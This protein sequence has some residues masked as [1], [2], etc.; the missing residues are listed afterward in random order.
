[1]ELSR[2]E[3][4]EETDDSLR[5]V[6]EFSSDVIEEPT[7]I[8]YRFLYR[9]ANINIRENDDPHGH[10]V[11]LLG[12][13]AVTGY[14]GNFVQNYI[15]GF[16]AEQAGVC[17]Y[18][19]PTIVDV[20]DDVSGG[21]SAGR[22]SAEKSRIL[23]IEFRKTP[24]Y[25]LSDYNPLQVAVL[26]GSD[27]EA[28]AASLLKTL[29]R[30]FQQDVRPDDLKIV[31][32]EMTKR[33]FRRLQMKNM[34][35]EQ[36]CKKNNLD[37]ERLHTLIFKEALE[38]FKEDM[39]LDAIFRHHGLVCEKNDEQVILVQIEPDHPDSLK[40]QLEETYSAG[41]LRQAAERQRTRRWLM[42]TARFITDES[43][44]S[45]GGLSSAE[46]LRVIRETVSKMQA[47]APTTN[48]P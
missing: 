16:V 12:D 2:C 46:A 22:W 3:R 31:L 8:A 24:R 44:T 35:V 7:R 23:S 36:Y 33:F 48:I 38:S 28:K 39:S 6:V 27:D 1:M 18:G 14:L 40:R 29:L 4:A 26:P 11:D 32:D 45:Y 20:S 43:A 5:Y 9:D 37:E 10:L 17:P 47:T 19:A 41:W 21:M 15:A 34:T 30:R 13:E 25:E 42:E